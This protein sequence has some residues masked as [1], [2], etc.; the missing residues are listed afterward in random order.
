MRSIAALLS[1]LVAAAPSGAQQTPAADTERV[2]ALTEV[3][4]PP[5]VQNPQDF[6][7]ALQEAYP[8]HLRESGVGGTVQLAFVVGADGQVGSV[9]VLSASDSSFAVPTVQAISRLRFSPA[10]VQG[11]AVAVRVEQPVAWRVQPLPVVA[12]APGTRIVTQGDS[13]NGYELS[14]VEDLPRMRNPEDFAWELERRYPRRLRNAGVNGTVVV[15]FRIERDGSTSSPSVLSAYLYRA[16]VGGC[17]SS[18]L[19]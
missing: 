4:V 6:A 9:R 18:G 16:P 8:A 14:G 1:V 19:R 3:E 15:R 13:V 10:R 2:Y 7:S 12:E 5:Q 17:T 11:R